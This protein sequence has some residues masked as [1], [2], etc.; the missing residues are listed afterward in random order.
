MALQPPRRLPS[1]SRQRST[2]RPPDP[3]GP[4][5]R[6]G[7]R[8]LPGS[9]LQLRCQSCSDAGRSLP[10]G[11]RRGLP[12][13]THRGGVYTPFSPQLCQPRAGGD[14]IS[15]PS[16]C[17]DLRH[18]WR[19]STVVA[20]VLPTPSLLRQIVGASL[21]FLLGLTLT[22]ASPQGPPPLS[23]SGRVGKKCYSC[24]K[25]RKYT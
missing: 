7:R 24:L 20:G 22:H 25:A 3:P 1:S 16:S 15:T 4:P 17:A 9:T 19:K 8:I 11:L 6:R 13:P 23:P 5:G 12:L 2:R 18:L 14:G 21:E 10:E